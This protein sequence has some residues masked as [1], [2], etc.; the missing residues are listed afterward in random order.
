[1]VKP[2]P[3][4]DKKQLQGSSVNK[5]RIQKYDLQGTGL[6]FISPSAAP[7]RERKKALG[8]YNQPTGWYSP[9]LSGCASARGTGPEMPGIWP[10]RSA[11]HICGPQ[12]YVVSIFNIRNYFN[13]E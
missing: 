11:V 5:S 2:L 9:C 4:S 1:M 6:H 13:T 3:V 10:V 12:D 7:T 8:V